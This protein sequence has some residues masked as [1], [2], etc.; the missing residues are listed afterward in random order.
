MKFKDTRHVDYVA[1]SFTAWYQ[2]AIEDYVARLDKDELAG[3]DAAAAARVVRNVAIFAMG[4]LVK[5]LSRN[6][7]SAA[8]VI[9]FLKKQH[10]IK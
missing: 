9:D 8:D 6:G 10:S 7:M 2:K 5:D 3:D 1:A 4:A